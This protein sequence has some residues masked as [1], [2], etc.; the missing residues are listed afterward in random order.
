MI[1]LHPLLLFVISLSAVYAEYNSDITLSPI[2]KT[3]TT[4]IG[5]KIDFPAVSDDEVTIVKVAIP[6]GKMTGWH[7]HLF[8]VFAY[9]L[10][11]T[12]SVEIDS[13][14]T[15]QFP[16]GTSFA[17]VINTYHNGINSGTTNVVLIAF[18]MGEKG[19]PLSIKK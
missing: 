6:P 16:Q 3:D 12:L 18:F 7:K 17:E 19:V 5:Q 14:A 13:S 11:G 2:L 4:S 15:L 10:E 8:P 9:V 1:K